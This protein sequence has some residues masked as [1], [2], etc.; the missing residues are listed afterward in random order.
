MA[1]DIS[2]ER[3]LRLLPDYS[4]GMGFYI[5][6]YS[7]KDGIPELEFNELGENNLI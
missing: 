6:N 3:A 4:Y 1:Q 5:L 7:I 2:K